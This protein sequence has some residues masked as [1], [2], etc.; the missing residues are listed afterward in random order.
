MTPL[1][2]SQSSLG[3]LEPIASDIFIIDPFVLHGKQLNQVR[4]TMKG[5]VVGELSLV[6][7]GSDDGIFDT[8]NNASFVPGRVKQ[9]HCLFQINHL[10]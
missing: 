7:R 4:F 10:F 9:F 6:F 5:K 1:H 2:R 8:S 3:P